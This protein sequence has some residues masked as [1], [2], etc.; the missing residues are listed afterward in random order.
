VRETFR[1]TDFTQ[2][3]IENFY[4]RAGVELDFDV[5]DFGTQADVLEAKD[6][7]ETALN[8]DSQNAA[9]ILSE[10]LNSRIAVYMKLSKQ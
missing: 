7:Y 3:D 10:K 8:D 4:Q 1:A 5:N 6:V 9:R 2:Q